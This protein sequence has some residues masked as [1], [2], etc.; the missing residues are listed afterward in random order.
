MTCNKMHIIIT[1]VLYYFTSVTLEMN[2]YKNSIVKQFPK[3]LEDYINTTIVSNFK[4]KSVF[5]DGNIIDLNEWLSDITN[6]DD[7]NRIIK[8]SKILYTIIKCE[9]ATS[10]YE[11]L[12]SIY[13]MTH[14]NNNRKNNLSSKVQ[15]CMDEKTI[16]MFLNNLNEKITLIITTLFELSDYAPNVKSDEPYFIKILLS[17]HLYVNSLSLSHFRNT[18]N[19]KSI[20]LKNELSTIIKMQRVLL[21]IMNQIEWFTIEYCYNYHKQNDQVKKKKI[22]LNDQLRNL[23]IMLRHIHQ[24]DSNSMINIDNLLVKKCIRGGIVV[25][26]SSQLINMCTSYFKDIIIKIT[27]VDNDENIYI[28]ESWSIN[29]LLNNMEYTYDLDLIYEYLQTVFKIL[30]KIIYHKTK[31]L[32]NAN[33]TLETNEYQNILL[34]LQLMNS[35]IYL[36]DHFKLLLSI[37]DY[38][39]KL[40]ID[41]S[42]FKLIVTSIIESKLEDYLNIEIPVLIDENSN[43]SLTEFMQTLLG[44]EFKQYWWLFNL[45]QNES[46]KKSHFTYNA[47][48]YFFPINLV[49]LRNEK[50][51]IEYICN[52]LTN[53]YC[54]L[55]YLKIVMNDCILTNDNEKLLECFS[56]IHKHSIQFSDYLLQIIR[57]WD[58]TEY[59]SQNSELLNILVTAI[60]HLR[61]E[62]NTSINVD[63][64]NKIINT[65]ELLVIKQEKLKRAWDTI[66]NLLDNYQIRNCKNIRNRHAMQDNECKDINNIVSINILYENDNWLKID[67]NSSYDTFFV[68]IKVFQHNDD[69]NEGV[70]VKLIKKELPNN[71]F[72]ILQLTARKEDKDKLLS[73]FSNKVFFNWYGETKC[74]NRIQLDIINNTMNIYNFV[75]FQILYLKWTLSIYYISWVLLMEELYDVSTIYDSKIRTSEISDLATS[76]QTFINLSILDNTD[77]EY[78]K[79]ATLYHFELLTILNKYKLL[80]G[81]VMIDSIKKIFIYP[82]FELLGIVKIENISMEDIIYAFGENNK[83]INLSTILSHLNYFMWSQFYHIKSKFIFI[84]A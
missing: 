20:K 14:C 75:D 71:F 33:K 60:I 12:D 84:D 79:K 21:Q 11:L 51:E 18:M 54:N 53:I 2:Y 44:I 50:K 45:L 17:L 24:I 78:L 1:I 4:S 68:S 9:C 8:K 73:A 29:E 80:S 58:V 42:T 31:E 57:K 72:D 7:E 82:I 81:E 26:E 67:N 49:Y 23:D 61:N 28:I 27:G 41:E 22:D 63:N 48:V 19:L 5:L 3:S 64:E 38:K 56:K 34:K 76:F 39:E 10:V 55:F 13:S 52:A 40:D 15:E 69:D 36:I 62:Y 47:N 25:N 35:P 43:L 59:L 16:I 83:T 70:F 77:N 46:K 65:N 6:N 30:M 66:I 74:I 32:L 37:N